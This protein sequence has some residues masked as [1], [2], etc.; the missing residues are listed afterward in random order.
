MGVTPTQQRKEHCDVR[1]RERIGY[2]HWERHVDIYGAYGDLWTADVTRQ[3]VVLI[4]CGS[5][6]PE[7]LIVGDGGD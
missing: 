4:D 1:V 7:I 2:Q 6:L 5:T 3:T